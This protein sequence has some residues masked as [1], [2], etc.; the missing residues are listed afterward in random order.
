M[1]DESLRAEIGRLQSENERFSADAAAMREALEWLRDHHNSGA[2]CHDIHEDEHFRIMD[3]V[4]RALKVDAV[5]SDP[6][7]KAAGEVTK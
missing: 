6:E 5:L 2:Q 1:S 3:V 7:C 4:E